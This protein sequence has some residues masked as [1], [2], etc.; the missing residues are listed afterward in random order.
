MKTKDLILV[1]LVCANVTL[2][3]MALA[4][5]VGKAE[6]SA[7]AGVATR[8]GDYVMVTGNV[9]N[10]REALLVIDVVAKRANL[11]TPK[12]GVGA[13]GQAWELTST[14]N[15]AADFGATPKP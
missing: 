1:A 10:S 7:V 8:S 5:Y 15:L 11:Y 9:A 13:G 6:P 14:R 2:A 4:L 3:A 12:A